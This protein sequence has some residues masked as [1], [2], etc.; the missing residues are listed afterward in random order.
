MKEGG[1]VVVYACEGGRE[2]VVCAC[3]CASLRS[4]AVPV[5]FTNLPNV[6]DCNRDF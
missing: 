6:V 3:E 5:I 1:E 4:A 2:A